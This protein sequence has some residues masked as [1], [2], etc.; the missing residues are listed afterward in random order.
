MQ[1]PSFPVLP[2]YWMAVWVTDCSAALSSR[3]QNSGRL[4][5]TLILEHKR[6][7]VTLV[8]H[9]PTRCY[10]MKRERRKRGSP[11]PGLD[12]LLGLWR[13]FL[14]C[15]CVASDLVP[16]ERNVEVSTQHPYVHRLCLFFS[17]PLSQTHTLL[18]SVFLWNTARPHQHSSKLQCM[19][20]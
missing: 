14:S 11:A 3:P 8:Q 20:P 18:F 4:S 1:T 13:S 7:H 17:L 12:R 2:F 9:L 10:E 5:H 6:W 16:K 15:R 19:S